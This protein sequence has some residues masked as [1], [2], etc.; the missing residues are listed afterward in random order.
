MNFKDLQFSLGKLTTGAYSHLAKKNPLQ[1]QDTKALAAWIF[2]ER[3]LL[4]VMRMLAYQHGETN[5]AFQDW[6]KEELR[7]GKEDD[8]RD[9]EVVICLVLRT[10][11]RAV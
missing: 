6:I 2:E 11:T 7:E 10:H 8:N 3:N 9:L 4:Y 1:K 5:R